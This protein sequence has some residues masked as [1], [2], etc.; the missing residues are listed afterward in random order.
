MKSLVKLL[1]NPLGKFLSGLVITGLTLLPISNAYSQEKIEKEKNKP[2]IE[3]AWKA[4]AGLDLVSEYV[5]SYSGDMISK[6]PSSQLCVGLIDSRGNNFFVWADNSLKHKDTDKGITEIDPQIN[7]SLPKNKFVK[8]NFYAGAFIVPHGNIT[9]E[10]GLN[11]SPKKDLPIDVNIYL[12]QGILNDENGRIVIPSI[13]KN[14]SLTDKLSAYLRADAP[15]LFHY[16]GGDGLSHFAEDV[17]LK[18]DLGNGWGVGGKIRHQIPIRKGIEH[19]T[20]GNISIS[21]SF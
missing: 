21:K 19:L 13:G 10:L 18:Y 9:G 4:Y 11:L 17:S 7:I 5:S 16:S 6:D 1:N 3:R 12:G 15:Y 2:K 20:T 8:G 14:I